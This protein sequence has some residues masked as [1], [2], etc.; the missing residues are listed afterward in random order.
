MYIFNHKQ[1]ST[2]KHLIFSLLGTILMMTGIAQNGGQ[3]PENNS[4]K[5]EWSGTSV[6]VTNKQP[7]ESV[8][9]VSYSQSDVDLTIPGN[10]SV[11]FMPPAAVATIKAKNTT[12]CGSSDFGWVELTLSAMP[13]K[14][15]SFDFTPIGNKEVVVTFETAETSN[16]RSYRVLISTDGVN[17][18]AIDSL[19]AD[20]STPNKR[21]SPK[22]VN[23]SVGLSGSNGFTNTV[24]LN[25]YSYYTDEVLDDGG[26]YGDSG[27]YLFWFD[28]AGNYQQYYPA[29]GTY[30]HI[31]DKP[32]RIK[33]ANFSISLE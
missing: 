22:T 27:N 9:Q 25:G 13:T 26:S 3:Y 14:F 1:K 8:I 7:C 6:K 4:V 23:N 18:R 2:M 5:L 21:L 11:I 32:L 20:A 24:K 33:K 12:N 31:S 17:Y 30:L 15:V 10:S 29:G 16:I 28:A 19:K